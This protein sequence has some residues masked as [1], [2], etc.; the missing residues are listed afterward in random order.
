MLVY[1]FIVAFVEEI[2]SLKNQFQKITLSETD[3]MEDV[4][5]QRDR[6]GRKINN[7]IGSFINEFLG[8]FSNGGWECVVI[9]AEIIDRMHT[10][11]LEK[12]AERGNRWME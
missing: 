12:L 8:T 10:K 9:F 2:F 11:F 5:I 7:T 1:N 3:K 6:D 4:R